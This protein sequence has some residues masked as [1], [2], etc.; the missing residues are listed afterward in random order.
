MLGATG[1][2]PAK[3]ERWSRVPK[4]NS[5]VDSSDECCVPLLWGE[6]SL[7]RISV[8]NSKDGFYTAAPAEFSDLLAS[9]ALP[10]VKGNYQLGSP[11]SVTTFLD[12]LN[13]FALR[14]YNLKLKSKFVQHPAR[15]RPVINLGFPKS[16]TTSL[17]K[18]LEKYEYNCVHWKGCYK[19]N[20]T[21]VGEALQEAYSRSDEKILSGSLGRYDC[22]TQLDRCFW[23][24]KTSQI[25]S[26]IWP[27]VEL[28]QSII[29]GYKHASYVL[30]TR[31]PFS[32]LRSVSRWSDLLERIRFSDSEGLRYNATD[33]EIVNWLIKSH[34]SI[35]SFFQEKIHR[36]QLFEIDINQAEYRMGDLLSTLQIPL[37]LSSSDER[38]YPR[39]NQARNHS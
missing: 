17:T 8:R 32:W 28:L 21:F 38:S 39:E 4:I 2:Q 30:T 22:F 12:V 15:S 16:G 11:K 27:Q 13:E 7:P 3:S 20:C 24:N 1:T 9:G 26:C 23:L 5:T 31:D 37:Q 14:S 29:Y 19:G 25:S 36:G 34:V 10:M 6:R 18:F 33:E 35:R